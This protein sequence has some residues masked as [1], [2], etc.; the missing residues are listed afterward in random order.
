MRSTADAARP[1]LASAGSQSTR[2]HGLSALANEWSF[3]VYI[4]GPLLRLALILDITLMISR[5]T[6]FRLA[7]LLCSWRHAA[8]AA[9][10]ATVSAA[11]RGEV[12]GAGEEAFAATLAAPTTVDRV[13]QAVR[14]G[15][16][17]TDGGGGAGGGAAAEAAR[18][19]H[20]QH[21]VATRGG[22]GGA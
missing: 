22:G 13:R 8:V 17:G 10:W 16:Y 7:P 3:N 18:R 12:A 9:L 11:A 4:Y 2:S 15:P 1:V 6:L 21:S 19:M 5:L 20:E 14:A